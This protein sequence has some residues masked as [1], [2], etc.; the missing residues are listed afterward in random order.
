MLVGMLYERRHSLE[1][2]SYG[3]AAT[4]A[5]WLATVFLVTTLASIG[6]PALNN[7]VGEFLVLQGAAVANF[8]WAA[9]AAIGVILSAVYMLWLYQRTFFGRASDDLTHHM[10]DLKGRE[11]VAL[12]PMLA[13][14]VWM[15]CFS[16]S[17]LPPI[18]A[19]NVKILEQ[20][21]VGVDFRVRHGGESVVVAKE[22]VHVR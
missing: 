5:P 17:F 12:L 6:L 19:Q 14:M 22:T 15:G 10:F 8:T 2:E 16:Q 3:G 1:I 4:P 7:F 21:K 9:C 11:W 18:S 13:M 20:S